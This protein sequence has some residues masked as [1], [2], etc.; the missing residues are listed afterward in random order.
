[1]RSDTNLIACPNENIFAYISRPTYSLDALCDIL[2]SRIVVELT[3]WYQCENLGAS[4]NGIE[5]FVHLARRVA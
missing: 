5:D 2:L 3:L 4:A 1:V